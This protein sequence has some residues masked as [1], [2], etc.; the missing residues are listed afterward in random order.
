MRWSPTLLLALVA[1]V[2]GGLVVADVGM[3][4]EVGDVPD[5]V[6]AGP[7]VGGAWYCAAGAVGDTDELTVVTAAPSG[8]DAPRSRR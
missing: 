6:A 2:V 8:S 3:P 4:S 7:A 1:L 5:P